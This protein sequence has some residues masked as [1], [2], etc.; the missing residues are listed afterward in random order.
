MKWQVPFRTQFD[1]K[2][3]LHCHKVMHQLQVTTFYSDHNA[4]TL[5]QTAVNP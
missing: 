3:L 4:L 5:C 1:E 2:G